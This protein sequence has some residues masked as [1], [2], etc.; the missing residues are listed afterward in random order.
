MHIK[1]TKGVNRGRK[2][3]KG[4]NYSGQNNEDKQWQIKTSLKK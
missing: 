3:K 2:F 1:K 4:R